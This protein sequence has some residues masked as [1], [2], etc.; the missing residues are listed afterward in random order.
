MLTPSFKAVFE[1]VEPKKELSEDPEK[2]EYCFKMAG[3]EVPKRRPTRD[4]ARTPPKKAIF[5][6]KAHAKKHSPPRGQGWRGV[7]GVGGLAGVGGVCGWRG[8]IPFIEKP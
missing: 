4:P 8:I 3:W 2:L 5:M 7:G 6:H 1:Y